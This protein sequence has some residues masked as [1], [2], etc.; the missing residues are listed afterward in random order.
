MLEFQ[1]YLIFEQGFFFLFVI[2]FEFGHIVK[3]LMTQPTYRA[4]L[5]KKL[6]QIYDNS[7]FFSPKKI[8]TRHGIRINVAFVVGEVLN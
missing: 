7:V 2:V 1:E 6:C 8:I 4:F 3:D 5:A